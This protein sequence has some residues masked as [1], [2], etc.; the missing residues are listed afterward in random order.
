MIGH[1]DAQQFLDAMSY[2]MYATYTL[3]AVAKKVMKYP[4]DSGL[5]DMFEDAREAANAVAS[6]SFQD[7][8]RLAPAGVKNVPPA[9]VNE[10]HTQLLRI[11][12][13]QL[14]LPNLYQDWEGERA[15]PA[16]HWVKLLTDET[17][18]QWDKHGGLENRENAVRAIRYYAGRAGRKFTTSDGKAVEVHEM[19]YETYVFL[20][21]NGNDVYFSCD[22]EEDSE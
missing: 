20:V 7:I 17:E 1:D 18:R 22:I 15:L 19:P 2:S 16:E 13:I 9:V 5:Q 11:R 6:L 21:S 10:I 3:G 12:G 8:A 4:K 14:A